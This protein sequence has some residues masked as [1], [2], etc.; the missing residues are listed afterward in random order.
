MM[1]LGL[2]EHIMIDHVS[3]ATHDLQRATAFYMA[4]L[5]PLGYSVQHQDAG[6]TIFG[7]DGQW[8]L[9]IYPAQ[10]DA[11]LVG[12][13]SHIAISAP[14]QLA[15]HAFHAHAIA[16]GASNLRTPGLR[17]DVNERYFGAM[18]TDP[19]QHTIEVVHWLA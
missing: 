3:I 4:C 1:A 2:K 9:A 19:D 10:G 13:R 8:S 16:N 5:E 15:T 14:S 11:P 7:V 12:Q 18:I 17:P 6:Q